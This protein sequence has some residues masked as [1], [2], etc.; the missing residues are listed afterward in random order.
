MK[1]PENEFSYFVLQRASL[2][3]PHNS[4]LYSS[5]FRHKADFLKS[6]MQEQEIVIHAAYGSSKDIN[7][8][9]SLG[10]KNEQMYIIGKPSRRQSQLPVNWISNGYTEHLSNLNTPGGS[11]PAEGNARLVLGQHVGLQRRRTFKGNQ[12]RPKDFAGRTTSYPYGAPPES[13]QQSLPGKCIFHRL[14]ATIQDLLLQPKHT[15][16]QWLI[17]QSVLAFE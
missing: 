17:L 10:L 14:K 7:V 13:S 8:Y 11:R 12:L 3:Y 6:L 9:S 16:N 2:D 1:L 15:L 4:C 5:S